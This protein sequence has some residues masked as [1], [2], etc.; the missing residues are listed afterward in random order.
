MSS[1]LRGGFNWHLDFFWEW[2]PPSE[3]AL[4]IR[5]PKE[6]F[7]TPAIAGGLFAV[8]RKWFEEV[9]TYDEGMNVSKGACR[10]DVCIGRGR[11]GHGTADVVREVT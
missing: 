2:L 7:K 11:G 4:R 9:G 1:Y 3:R 5:R 8:D 6:P 10:Y